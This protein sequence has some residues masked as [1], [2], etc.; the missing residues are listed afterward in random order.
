MTNG[1]MLADF[2]ATMSTS[3]VADLEGVD[4]GFLTE[5]FSQYIYCRGADGTPNIAI[6]FVEPLGGNFIGTLE[7]RGSTS[8]YR[9]LLHS[10]PDSS[11]E[12]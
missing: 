12:S 6:T 7:H 2:M 9:G 3:A 1:R 10:T 5:T 11:V 8:M 4:L